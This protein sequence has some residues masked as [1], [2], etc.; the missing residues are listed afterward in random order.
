MV[1]VSRKV[2][3]GS[4]IKKYIKL[5]LKFFLNKLRDYEHTAP[6]IF[7]ESLKIQYYKIKI[8]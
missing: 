7:G 6:Y 3:K 8:I 2:L 4:N 1:G 5:L